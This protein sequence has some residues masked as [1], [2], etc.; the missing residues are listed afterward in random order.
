MSENYSQIKYEQS[1]PIT[2]KFLKSNGNVETADGDT[3][4]EL[5]DYGIEKYNQSVP[6]ADKF[7]HPDGSIKQMDGTEVESGTE[8]NQKR[9]EQAAPIPAKFLQ[10][11][12]TI[13]S[14]LEKTVEEATIKYKLYAWKLGIMST[15]IGYLENEVPEVGDVLM[16]PENTGS[17]PITDTSQLKKGFEI[18]RII[19]SVIYAKV[20]ESSTEMYFVRSEENDYVEEIEKILPMP[21]GLQNGMV[22]A[23]RGTVYKAIEIK[24]EN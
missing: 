13:T 18:T 8:Y 14:H 24:V 15:T 6:I 17:G 4:E 20:T 7:L 23:P 5:A 19:N 12:G 22:V 21:T 1:T 9:Y 16:L 10:M 11:D 3:V 2:D